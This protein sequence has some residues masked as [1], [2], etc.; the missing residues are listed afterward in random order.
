[1]FDET[2]TFSRAWEFPRGIDLAV[3]REVAEEGVEPHD[4]QAHVLSRAGDTIQVLLVD[5]VA[6]YADVVVYV[7]GHGTFEVARREVWPGEARP[8][9]LLTLRRFPR[10]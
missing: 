1:V 8:R 7:E 4:F 3:V 2:E 9:V 5:G 6:A 10:P